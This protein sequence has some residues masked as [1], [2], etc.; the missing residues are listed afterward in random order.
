M[1]PDYIRYA[2]RQATPDYY[3]DDDVS[4][5]DCEGRCGDETSEIRFEVGDSFGSFEEAERKLKEF[6]KVNCVKFWKR[7]AR[8]IEA[9]AKRVDR[10]ISPA[11]KYYQLKYACIHGG[12]KFR[13]KGDGQ[14]KTS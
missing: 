7:E 6:E 13:G 1:S 9:A 12:Q 11:L 5:A 4:G 14:R 8:T 10:H 3:V 2:I